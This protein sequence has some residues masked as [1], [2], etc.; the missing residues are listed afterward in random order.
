[1]K[2][3]IS[4]ISI[5][6]LMVSIIS[7]GGGNKETEQTENTQTNQTE[8][9]KVYVNPTSTNENHNTDIDINFDTTKYT[10]EYIQGTEMDPMPTGYKKIDEIL[11]EH[12]YK[13]PIYEISE[14]LAEEGLEGK[15][16]EM[17]NFGDKYIFK[18]STPLFLAVQFGYNDLAKELIKEGADVNARVD[19]M[20]TEGGIDM[21]YYAV[22]N[23]NPEM[24]KI[25]IDKG[26]DK[27]RDYGYEYSTYLTDIAIGNNNLDI[28]KL[29]VKR[30]DSKETLIPKAVQENNIEMVKYLLSI[31]QDI[32][33][34]RFFDG[35]WVDSPLK[36][37]AENGYIEMAKFL[38]DEGANLNSADDYM[39]Y[40]YNNYDITKLLVDNDVFNLN[41]NTTREEAIKLV[42]DGKYYEIEKLLLSEDSNN[43]DGYDELMNAI[44]KGDMKALEK[45]VKDDTDLNKQYDKITPLGLAAARNDKEMV[46]FL[47]EKG[48]DI[49]LEDGYGY[50]PLIIAMKYRNIGL[51]KDI[52]DL[53]PDLNAICSATGDTPLTYL[54]DKVKFG[55]DICYYLIKNGADVNKKNNNGD[56]PLIV[57][58]QNFILSYGMLGVLINMGADYNIKNKEGKTAMDIVIEKDD[59]ATLHHLNNPD[60]LEYYLTI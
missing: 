54:V 56:T 6:V 5:F 8:T 46:K 17:T 44:S 9:N 50:T 23:N 28:L 35:F 60:D 42:K 20:E 26:L 38:I 24:T 53:K 21:L 12:K 18:D 39:L 49:N 25:L 19:N 55:S 45:L 29:L 11:N 16:T 43:I 40:A 36:V 48:A 22:I 59:K 1:M 58:V 57:S 30:G 41:T 10:N 4:I 32:D 14:L 33:A 47:V 27:N 3:I 51:A 7:C 15:I 13:A 52:I 37:A 2:N 31:G 34:Q